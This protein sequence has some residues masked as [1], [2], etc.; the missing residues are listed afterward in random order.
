VRRRMNCA[1]PRRPV[2]PPS[3]MPRA[4]VRR[5]EP[6]SPRPRRAGAR[7]NLR[8]N[9]DAPLSRARLARAPCAAHRG[10]DAKSPVRG[11][12]SGGGGGVALVEAAAG[13]RCER[14][15]RITCLRKS[16]DTYDVG[17][18]EYTRPSKPR[19]CSLDS[20][21]D[22]QKYISLNHITMSRMLNRKDINL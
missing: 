9:P 19:S 11:G 5:L 16:L 4:P 7:A 21:N 17:N 6:G 12:R 8:W 13:E 14:R 18:S 10:G 3:W 1:A 2:S 20:M 22:K 15:A